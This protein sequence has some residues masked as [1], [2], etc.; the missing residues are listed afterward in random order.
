MYKKNKYY[1]R[2]KVSSFKNKKSNHILNARKI[3]NIQNITPNKE[4][5]L[6]TGCSL[7]AL[8]KIVKKLTQ[9]QFKFNSFNIIYKLNVLLKNFTTKL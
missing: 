2:K 5:S 6:K 9:L 7:S 1:T 8:N 3:Y 4:L